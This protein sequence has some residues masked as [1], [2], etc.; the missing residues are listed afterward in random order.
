MQKNRLPAAAACLLAL[1]AASHA[2]AEAAKGKP[3]AA[4]PA[5]QPKAPPSIEMVAVPA[6]EFWMGCGEGEA[7]CGNDEKPR[8][9]VAMKAF[10]LGKHEVTQGQWRAVMG[11]NPAWFKKCG[12]HCPVENVSWEGAQAFIGA[13]NRLTGLA[14]RLPTE[15]EWEYAARAGTR[16]PF[17]TGPCIHTRQANYDGSSDYN[18]C[19][20]KTGARLG[21]T[22]PVDRYPANPWGLHGL[23]GNVLEW[24]Q[25]CYHDG[26]Q[27]AP[28]DGKAWEG[29]AGGDGRVARG[30]SWV[31]DPVWVRSAGRFRFAPS[32]RSDQLGFRLA[33]D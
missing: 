11:G 3:P 31:N 19:G 7:E 17:S 28:A 30:G 18:R 12:D 23:H 27:G 8:H 16:T 6:G 15:A 24:A 2:Q 20:A 10:K 13:L 9:R 33:L 14:Y 25:D 26:Y 1:A 4:P 22:A 32:F 29:C 21:K 5:A